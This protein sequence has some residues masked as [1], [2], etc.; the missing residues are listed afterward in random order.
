MHLS[1]RLATALVTVLAATGGAV[2]SAPSASAGVT[3]NGSASVNSLANL[4]QTFVVCTMVKTYSGAPAT[5]APSFVNW[6][7]PVCWLEPQYSGAG[8]KAFLDS[9]MPFGPSYVQQLE[10]YYS[11]TQPPYHDGES[12]MFWGVGCR[13]DDLT[14]P[15]V[16]PSQMAADGLSMNNPW[17][18]IAAGAPVTQPNPVTPQILAEYAA[19]EVIPPALTFAVNPGVLQTVNVSTRVYS[20]QPVGTYVDLEAQADIAGMMTSTV[21][22]TPSVLTIDPGGPAKTMDGKPASEIQCPIV[23]GSFGSP[24]DDSCAFYYTK[25]TPA[26]TSYQLTASI[27]WTYDWVEHPDAGGFPVSVIVRGAPQNVTVQEIQA[28]VGGQT[29]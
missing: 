28:I 15:S 5:S 6:T 9:Q 14:W 20:T 8:L 22:A 7:P 3:C 19:A 11:S 29:Q 25:A 17:V 12:G 1:R 2:A 13:T 26:G 16:F 18:W 24:D 10:T 21:Q 4:G 27:T 23:D